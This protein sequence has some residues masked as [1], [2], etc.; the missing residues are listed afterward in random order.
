MSRATFGSLAAGPWVPVHG[1]PKICIS[2]LHVRWLWVMGWLVPYECVI[3]VED[4]AAS[5]LEQ[6]N[7]QKF[8]DITCLEFCRSLRHVMFLRQHSG[9]RQRGLV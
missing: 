7:K 3:K 1:A 6:T 4:E 2:A 5:G 8:K 9:V